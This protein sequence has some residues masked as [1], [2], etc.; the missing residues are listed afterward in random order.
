MKE[1]TK[2]AL[3]SMNYFFLREVF[4][5]N[6]EDIDFEERLRICMKEELSLF[7]NA[8]SKENWSEEFTK[9][10]K[11]E[12]SEGEYLEDNDVDTIRKKFENAIKD[13]CSEEDSYLVEKYIDIVNQI[14]G[15]E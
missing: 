3:N 4:N 5:K 14:L 15:E 6:K 13:I 11:T 8:I 12:L 2:C 1:S 7:L 9:I 10:V